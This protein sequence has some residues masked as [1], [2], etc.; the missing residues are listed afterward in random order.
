MYTYNILELVKDS[1]GIVQRVKSEIVKESVSVK[2]SFIL[3]D[4]SENPNSL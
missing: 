3:L 4:P 2:V 1:D